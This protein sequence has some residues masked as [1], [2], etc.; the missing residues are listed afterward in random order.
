M[1]PGITT[2]DCL[3]EHSLIYLIS[4]DAP[5]SVYPAFLSQNIDSSLVVRCR[6]CMVFKNIHDGQNPVSVQSRISGQL[7]VMA[8]A[9]HDKLPVNQINRIIKPDP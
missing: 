1:S 4:P 5:V 9:L 2:G 6:Q 7:I 8:A 3:I